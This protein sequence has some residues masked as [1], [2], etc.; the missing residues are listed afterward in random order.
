MAWQLATRCSRPLLD[1]PDKARLEG[2]DRQLL[3]MADPLIECISE[4]A[5]LAEM[6]RRAHVLPS[7]WQGFKNSRPKCEPVHRKGQGFSGQ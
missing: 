1:E 6:R 3:Q 4:V 7:Y 2:L 5:S